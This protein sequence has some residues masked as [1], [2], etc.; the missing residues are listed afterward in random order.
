MSHR[1]TQIRFCRSRDGTRIAYAVSGTGLPL[2]WVPH[3]VH[4]LKFDVG[5]PIWSPWLLALTE[6][7][8]VIRYDWRG[9]GL[10]D[11]DCADLSFERHVEDLEAVVAAAGFERFVLFGMAFGGQTALTYAVRH[12]RRVSH[13]VLYG[14]VCHGRMS[15]S[16][17]HE[18]RAEAQT[19]L[20]AIELGWPDE[21]SGYGQ[22]Y[23]SLHLPAAS[24]EQK[25]LYNEQL[26]AATSQANAIGLMKAFYVTDLREAARQVHCPT[27]ILHAREDSLVPFDQGRSTA[28][29]VPRARFV[30]LESRN[31]LVLNSDLSWPQLVEELNSFIPESFDAPVEALELKLDDLTP[32]EREILEIMAQGATNG[33]IAQQL[34]ISEKTVRNQVSIILDKLGVT[35]RLQAVVQAREAGFGRKPPSH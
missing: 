8:A 21:K 1:A 19:R 20:K 9:C 18:D 34:G 30:P 5:N 10:S 3:W 26:H 22:F 17:T 25:R 14:M 13:L 32:R 7:H 6:R 16:A 27:L 11:R 35:G 24:A 23:A 33:N 2:V 12:P 15:R 29:L 4:T 28:T 31:H